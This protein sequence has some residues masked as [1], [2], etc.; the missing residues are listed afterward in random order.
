MLE[1][2]TA[3]TQKVSNNYNKTVGYAICSTF[4]GLIII[5]SMYSRANYMPKIRFFYNK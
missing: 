4:L 3:Q 1:L 2:A 5:F